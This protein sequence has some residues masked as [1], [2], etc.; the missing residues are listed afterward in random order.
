M[1]SKKE[2][3][4][5]LERKYYK[6]ISKYIR[7]KYKKVAEN[8]LKNKDFYFEKG[9]TYIQI[10]KYKKNIIKSY[11]PLI[12]QEIE[13][14]YKSTLSSKKFEKALKSEEELCTKKLHYKNLKDY[15]K[16]PIHI[17][18][19]F[20]EALNNEL[21]LNLS[22][23][24]KAFEKE[25]I[26]YLTLISLYAIIDCIK[27]NFIV[28]IGTVL[29]FFKNTRDIRINLPDSKINCP[30]IL[31]DRIVPKIKLCP[32][33]DY[34]Y[35][36]KINENNKAIMNYYKEKMERYLIGIKVKNA[37]KTN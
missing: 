6:R 37:D 26:Q 25:E 33:F 20:L 16:F 18:D 10:D 7:N 22:Q 8:E 1:K 12:Q 4:K 35:F 9:K 11:E 30:R 34:K 23:N 21:N 19:N 5:A 24:E 32:R 27:E 36:L 3:K 15:Q 17:P 14:M 13:D 2:I 31:E 29:K 28:K